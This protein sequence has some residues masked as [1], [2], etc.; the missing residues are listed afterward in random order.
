[1]KTDTN[2]NFETLEVLIVEDN[3]FTS[4]ILRKTLNSLEVTKI[5]SATDGQEALDKMEE[6]PTPPDVILLD[7]RMPGMGGVELLTRLADRQYAGHV[8]LTSGVDEEI[9]ASVEQLARE[10]N[11]RLL[12]TLPKPLNAQSLSE[13]LSQIPNDSA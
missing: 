6:N 12:G 9:L 8:I 3:A 13:L 11:I 2:N 7:L 5:S 10:K 4:I 1:M